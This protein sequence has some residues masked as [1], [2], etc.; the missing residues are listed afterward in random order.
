VLLLLLTF[1]AGGCVVP[2][3]HPFYT[4]ETKTE[5][6]PSILG[7]W[8]LIND[9]FNEISPTNTAAINRIKP[10]VFDDSALLTHDPTNNASTLEATFFTVNNQLYCDLVAGP[11][12]DDAAGINVYWLF[13]VIP[14]HALCKV[15]QKK[16][17][18]AFWSL[19]PEWVDD[20][21]EKKTLSI[22]RVDAGEPDHV[23][24]AS[25]AEW[26]AFLKKFAKSEGIFGEE[27]VIVLKRIEKKAMSKN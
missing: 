16:D 18:L 20:A 7:E 14:V 8:Q 3:L 23:Y 27:P 6:P 24:T 13:H 25:S 19:Q 21:I 5:T 17:R 22:S 2:S 11:L 12:E 15:E 4:D 1:Y 26:T 9:P 10:W